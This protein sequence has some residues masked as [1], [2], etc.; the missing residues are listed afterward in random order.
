MWLMVCFG[1]RVAEH[2]TGRGLDERKGL[3][4]ERW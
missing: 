3:L 1:D 4:A 2:D